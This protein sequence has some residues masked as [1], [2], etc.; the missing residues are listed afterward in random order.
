MDGASLMESLCIL[1]YSLLRFLQLSITPNQSV[2]RTIV[3]QYRFGG[4]FEVRNNALR[5]D[6][7]EFNA[8]LI[9]R[10]DVPEDTLSEYRVLVERDQLAECFGVELSS[11]DC[12]RGTIAFKDAVRHKPIR[13]SLRFYL[14]GSLTKCQGLGLGEH[15]G[16]QDVVMAAQPIRSPR[17]RDEVARDQ[18]RALMDQLVK[19]VLTVCSRLTPID[20]ASL[21]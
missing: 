1:G 3:V 20:G 13:R 9:E 14:L 15:I 12:V 16:Q 10:I 2:G 5:Q 4:V 18:A 21:S 8:P 6:F 7:A 19:R 11:Q 17:E